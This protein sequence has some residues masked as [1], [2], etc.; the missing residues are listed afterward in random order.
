MKQ[1]ISYNKPSFEH[2]APDIG[3]SLIYKR[4][5]IENKNK[6]PIW[7]YHPEIELVYV[8]EGSGKRQ[9][10]SHVSYYQ[11]GDLICIGAN[12][13]HCGFTDGFSKT[14][15]ET[16]IQMLP[17]YLGEKFFD[18]SE[19]LPI[20][21]LLNRAKQG[22]VFFGA[23]KIEVGAIIENMYTK[24]PFERIL[25]SLL[26]LHKLEASKEY[27]ILNAEGFTLKAQAQDNSRINNTFNY[28][29]K[30]FKNQISIE[31]ISDFVN[32]TPP[33]FCRNFKKVTG[34]TFTQFVNEYR[35][36]HATKLLT[37]KQES[38]QGICFEC[39]FNNFSHFN[40]VFKKYTGKTPTEYRKDMNF[41]IS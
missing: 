17:E 37:E 32:M 20:K 10:G 3:N 29:Q 36:V 8:N 40:K 12:L 5:N 33:A 7:H 13:P 39:G 9:I 35:L 24:S 27:E 15:N 1:Q 21:S 19:M 14:R 38:I 34:K 22:L 18:V 11:N 31:E 2:L 4:F 41:T 26:I 30:N 28:V 23:T 25:D 16:V 6:Q